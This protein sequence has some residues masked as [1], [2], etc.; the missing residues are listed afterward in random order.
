MAASP[1]WKIYDDKG[2]YQ[3]AVKEAEAAACL[4]SFYGLGATIR[5]GHNSRDIVWTEGREEVDAA[6]SYDTVAATI[7]RRAK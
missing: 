7:H 6:E 1:R 2:D 3:A 5:R 4:V